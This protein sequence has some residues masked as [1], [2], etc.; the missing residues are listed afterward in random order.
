MPEL[1]HADYQTY[2]HP[3]LHIREQVFIHEQQVPP[4]LEMDEL[5]PLSQHV[6]LLENGTPVATGRLTPD[7]HIGRVAVL[8]SFRGRG[9][10]QRIIQGLEKIA[11]Q[12]GLDRVV[13]GAQCRAITFY[14]KLGYQVAGEVFMDAGIEHRMMGK[15]LSPRHK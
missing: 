9:F 10:G 7:G 8:S 2:Q 6:L 15:T 14:Q 12:R 3:I 13:L 1:I 5:D 11:L 4:E